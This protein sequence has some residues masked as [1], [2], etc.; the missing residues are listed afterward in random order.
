MKIED[1]DHIDKD[2]IFKE[3]KWNI[4]YIGVCLF[5]SGLFWTVSFTMTT[6]SAFLICYLFI[7]MWLYLALTISKWI[8]NVV[9]ELLIYSQKGKQCKL[10]I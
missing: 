1:M 9:R 5:Q 8:L 4:L 7:A 10:T 6:W 2:S 3:L